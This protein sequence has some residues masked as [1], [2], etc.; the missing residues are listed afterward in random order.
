MNRATILPLPI[1]SGE[2]VPKPIWFEGRRRTGLDH[3]N[4][5]VPVLVPLYGENTSRAI[6]LS[7]EEHFFAR[8]Q[9][10]HI[11]RGRWP[12]C[13]ALNLRESSPPIHGATHQS[14]KRNHCRR[15]TY[16]VHLPRANA[17][18]C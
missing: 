4:E 7:F 17:S 14:A 2:L 8:P 13:S 10:G 5:L 1:G 18:E 9:G 11:T 15:K 16:V 6:R 3:V 12:R